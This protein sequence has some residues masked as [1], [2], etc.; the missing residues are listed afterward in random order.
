MNGSSVGFEAEYH[1]MRYATLLQNYSFQKA[2]KG[3]ASDNDDPPRPRTK[4]IFLPDET[5]IEA[6]GNTQEEKDSSEVQIKSVLVENISNR[7]SSSSSEDDEPFYKIDKNAILKSIAFPSLRNLLGDPSYFDSSSQEKTS[8]DEHLCYPNHPVHR[9]PSL[10]IN[11]D[12]QGDVQCAYCEE[13]REFL[14]EKFYP[15]ARFWINNK[16]N[17][18]GIPVTRQKDSVTGDY[19]DTVNGMK[20]LKFKDG[21]LYKTVSIRSICYKVQPTLD[22]IEKFCGAKCDDNERAE[23]LSFSTLPV[24]NQRKKHFKEG[25]RV[26]V[27]NEELKII[28]G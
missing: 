1:R 9:T 5:K 20:F 10:S 13:E 25:D 16:A 15:P 18:L 27:L 4:N 2:K 26:V 8:G 28:Q 23:R 3:Y 17:A 24:K 11:S 21:F 7:A 12:L 19:F 6:L 14:K 22:D